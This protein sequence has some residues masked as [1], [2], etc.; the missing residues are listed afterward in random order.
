MQLQCKPTSPGMHTENSPGN[1]SGTENIS[2]PAFG[3]G[4]AGTFF[5][6]RSLEVWSTTKIEA[7]TVSSEPGLR[8]ELPASGAEE[9][10]RCR[11]DQAVWS[12][13]TKMKI[14]IFG[15]TLSSSWGNGHATP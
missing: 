2:L 15:L 9:E 1:G 7:I 10:W 8:G 4:T 6:E 14:T 12:E 11:Y 3:Y 5:L 13:A